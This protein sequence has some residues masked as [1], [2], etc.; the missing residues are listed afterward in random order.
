MARCRGGVR[1][2][3]HGQFAAWLEAGGAG[4]GGGRPVDLL[5]NTSGTTN[6]GRRA[7]GNWRGA[8]W[9]GGGGGGRAALD[10]EFGA[11]RGAGSGAGGGGPPVDLLAYH[12]VHS[13]QEAK[14]R[15]YLR[16]AGD[17]AAGAGA[18]AAAEGHYGALLAR[19]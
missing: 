5:A 6:R 15:E 11:W 4:G 10:G 13:D 8:G 19:L 3:L 18:F 12:Y 17:A 2:A 14:A 9:G 7:R 16:R 1:A